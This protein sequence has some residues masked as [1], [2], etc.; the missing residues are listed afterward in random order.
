MKNNFLDHL[1]GDWNDIISDTYK[2]HTGG[3][4]SIESKECM[5][6]KI[7]YSKKFKQMEYY[8]NDV[9]S[10]KIEATPDIPNIIIFNRYK[11]YEILIIIKHKYVFINSKPY[12]E[13]FKE[14]LKEEKIHGETIDLNILLTPD[15]TGEY[16]EP[17]RKTPYNEEHTVYISKPLEDR[18]KQE[19]LDKIKR[20][21]NAAMYE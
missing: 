18:I 1:D 4:F 21:I 9:Y 10:I 16:I 17:K 20:E 5:P 2:E 13:Y 11:Q 3:I 12:E 6:F 15:F 7:Y 19:I 14:H 8:T